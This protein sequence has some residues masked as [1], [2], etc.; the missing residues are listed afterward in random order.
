MKTIYNQRTSMNN[1]CKL[2]IYIFKTVFTQV[3]LVFVN[4][5]KHSAVNNKM[6]K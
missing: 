1:N 3:W 2:Y 4:N 6:N 5:N